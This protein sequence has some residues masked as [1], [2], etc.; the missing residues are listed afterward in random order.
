MRKLLAAAILTSVTLTSGMALA[1]VKTVTLAV[2]GMYCPSC[3]YIVKKSIKSVPG[4]SKVVVSQKDETAV[5]TFDD[6]KV[7]IDALTWATTEAGY[8]SKLKTDK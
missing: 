7:N 5:V 8:P 4:V 6:A 2:S 3:P 1:A